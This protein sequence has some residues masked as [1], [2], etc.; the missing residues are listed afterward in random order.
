ME[1]FMSART[2]KAKYKNGMLE[3]LEKVELPEGAE[4]TIFIL[5]EVDT[6]ELEDYLDMRNPSIKKQIRDGYEEYKD[7]KT[8]TSNEFFAELRS[9]LKENFNLQK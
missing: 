9:E 5:S 2:V 6:A 4:V 3:L 7:G 1:A 8:R